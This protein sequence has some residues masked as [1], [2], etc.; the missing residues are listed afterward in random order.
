MQRIPERPAAAAESREEPAPTA[1]L[2][3]DPGRLAEIGAA[4]RERFL[5]DARGR[6]EQLAK[7]GDPG[8]L[9]QIKQLACAVARD[10][11]IEREKWLRGATG[12]GW[13]AFF[14]LVS[15]LE[16]HA[17]G[18]PDAAILGCGGGCG[19]GAISAAHALSATLSHMRA[20]IPRAAAWVPLG[21]D[22]QAAER[23]DGSVRRILAGTGALPTDRA[24]MKELA[25]APA[26]RA[27]GAA[28]GAVS[29]GWA[30]IALEEPGGGGGGGWAA[31]RW[32]GGRRTDL[33]YMLGC[34]EAGLIVLR[35]PA[36][37]GRME[38]AEYL[39]RHIPA[40]RL[41]SG[42][43]ARGGAGRIAVRLGG[44]RD[45]LR[46]G[47]AGIKAHRALGGAFR[48]SMA[49]LEEALTVATGLV[50]LRLIMGRAG[51]GR[52]A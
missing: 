31:A 6:F 1:W 30:R 47:L 2:G 41:A 42:G 20:G 17:R 26:D 7:G 33:A 27:G 11:A 12:L 39:R 24:V 19:S 52:G 37:A 10:E 32:G 18:G 28:G 46:R 35:G 36:V 14:F 9:R 3:A 5:K 15:R 21:A 44:G 49:D 34:S 50:N 45:A 51:G 23:A 40:A 16:E 38:E 4:R 13:T 8:R 25:A 43:A 29:I 22:M 48:G